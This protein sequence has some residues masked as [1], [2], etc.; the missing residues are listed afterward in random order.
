[1]RG[2]GVVRE[3]TQVNVSGYLPLSVAEVPNLD[4]C[5]LLLRSR[6]LHNVPLTIYS[7]A[8]HED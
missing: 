2:D 8:R 6:L 5:L 4:G 1:M 7:I 3:P